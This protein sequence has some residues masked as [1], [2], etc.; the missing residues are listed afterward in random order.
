MVDPIIGTKWV[1]K[2]LM[3]G[4]SG[5]NIVYDETLD[6]MGIDRS[7]ICLTGMPFHNIMPGKQGRATWAD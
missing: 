3:D 6:A 7:R 1:T 4:A 2:V 5:L